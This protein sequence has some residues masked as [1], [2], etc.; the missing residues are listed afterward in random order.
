MLAG[1]EMTAFSDVLEGRSRWAVLTGK[2]QDVLAGLGDKSVDNVITDPPYTGWVQDRLTTNTRSNG[3]GSV[4]VPCSFAALADFDHVAAGLRFA[5]RW[6]IFFCAI[7]QLGDYQHAAPDEWIRSGVYRKERA[8][9]QFSG[10]RP[11]NACEGLAIFHNKGRKRW[12]GG[13]SHAFW[14]AMP[15]ARATTG[16]PTAKPLALMTRI[17]E[18]FTDPGDL[19]LD[20]FC[21]S[22]TT[23]VAALRLG[24][25]FV[26]VEM[27]PTW[28]DAARERLTAE[29][30]NSTAAARE[31]G[32]M[33]MF[34]GE[35]Q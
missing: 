32:Q 31:A 28:A 1:E 4:V 7:E 25:R 20:P 29:C 12:N 27:N 16:H 24:R 10:D 19:I 34:G 22:G 18:L 30:E 23:G 21:G 33:P 8:C 9:P 3:R 13:G 6:S 35:K 14:Q 5:K 26:G 2:W 15:E 17:V 11:G